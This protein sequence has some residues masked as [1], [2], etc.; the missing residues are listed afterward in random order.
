MSA[1]PGR[2][3]A[4]APLLALALLFAARFADALGGAVLAFRDAG[5]FFLPLR[6]VVA[7]ALRSGELPLWNDFASAGRALAANPNGAVFWPLTPLLA[8]LSP[9]ALALVHAALAVLL[10]VLALRW[11]GLSPWAASAGGAVLLLSGAFQTLPI[12][13]TTIASAAP[14]PLAAVALAGLDPSDA[15]GARRRA[16]VAGLSLGVSLLGGEPVITAIG[17]AGALLLA[18][19]RGVLLLR[20]GERRGARGLAAWAL[21]AVLLSVL[22]SSVQLLPALGELSRSARGEGL[23]PEEGALFWSVAPSRLLT[24]LEPRLTGDPF[25][26]RDEEYW[27]A[28]TFDAGNPY[29]Y[30]LAVG[31]LPLALALSAGRDR[32]GRAALLLAGAGALLSLGRNLPFYEALG[33]VTSFARY[34]EKW[35]L[36]ATYGLAAGAA[37]GAEAV[38]G[39]GDPEARRAAR[40][41]F[42]ATC[43]VLAAP[44]LLLGLLAFLSPAVLRSVLWGLGLGTGPTPAPVVA[45]ALVQPLVAASL[46]LVLCAALARRLSEGR[47]GERPVAVA[48]AALFLLDGARRVAGSCPATPREVFERRTPALEAVLAET[49]RGRFHDD[50]ADLAGVAVRRAREAGGLDPLRPVTGI[51]FGVRYAGENDVD[52]M[53]SAGSFGSVK[54]LSALPWGEE[55]L[56]RLVTQGVAVVRTPAGGAE[57]PGTEEIR[58]D[59]GDRL[60]RVLATRPQALLVPSA[61]AVGEGGSLDAVVRDPALALFTAAVELPGPGGERSYGTGR[62]ET[63]GRTA[64]R[65]SLRVTCEGASCLL[66][67]ARSFDP[68]FRAEVD[69]RAVP[70]VVADGFL[71]ALEVPAGAHGVVLSYRN[72]LLLAGALATGAG[73]LVASALLLTARRR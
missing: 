4:S 47:L 36:L 72:P 35:W 60:V 30:D 51:L 28:G 3:R 58:R 2:L 71:T 27:G 31:L 48:L 70:T 34:P 55:K 65:L 69:G 57:L 23:R 50:A 25:A 68:S 9:T 49:P 53:T 59:G 19:A 44:V 20:S 62:V 64:S 45:G 32:R 21:A 56:A 43:L 73:L 8:L 15:R 39:G 16:A 66:V 10:L 40:R 1:G 13:A 61:L 6:H 42:G 11:A 37:V 29:F 26:E 54:R 18:A 46:S 14:L 38:L 41:R 67:L 52:R 17:G 22:V 7:E 12:L 63:T 24:L 33:S 5:Y